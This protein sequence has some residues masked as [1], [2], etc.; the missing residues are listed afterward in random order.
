MK[1]ET[2][3]Q[4]T[5][6]R[7]SAGG[8]IFKKEKNDI[9]VALILRNEGKV[10]CLPKGL[11]DEGETSEETALREIKEETGLNGQILGKID[12]ID[13][14]FTFEN[15]KIHKTVHFYLVKHLGGNT[16][17]H[18]SE[19]EDV[20]WFAIDNAIETLT[21]ENEIKIMRKAKAECQKI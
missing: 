2:S 3:S 16:K 1:K 20:K 14:W 11:I 12:S 5:E 21:Y 18:D 7:T 19:V 4:K 9:T 15:T 17:D 8:V 6:I 13:Y 10:W